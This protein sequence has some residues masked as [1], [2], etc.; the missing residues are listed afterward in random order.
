MSVGEAKTKNADFRSNPENR[1][2]LPEE[3][4]LLSRFANLDS[5]SASRHNLVW[6]D[7]NYS[8]LHLQ[9]QHRLFDGGAF[10]AKFAL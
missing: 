6:R 10:A 5:N 1:V 7:V 8:I 3:K 9:E 2:C 4:K